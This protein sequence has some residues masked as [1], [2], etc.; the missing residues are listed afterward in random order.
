M[1]PQTI[2]KPSVYYFGVFRMGVAERRLWCKDELIPLTPKQFDL[3]TY[4]V[5]H[6]GHVMKKSELLD[7]IWADTCVEETT[8]ARNVSWLRKTIGEYADRE[9]IFETVAKIGY[10]FTAVVKRCDKNAPIVE[11]QT[12][13]YFRGEETITL[14]DAAATIDKADE[15]GKDGSENS[16]SLWP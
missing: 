12:I 1:N 13:P 16:N 2:E 9:A 5:E 4:F 10:R 6:S 7:A 8:L 14:D 3:L 15:T 11:E